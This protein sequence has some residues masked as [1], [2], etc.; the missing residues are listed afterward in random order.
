ME[1]ILG[2]D[3][4]WF[5]KPWYFEFHDPDLKIEKVEQGKK[6][7]EIT[8]SNPGGMP[9]P[10][11]LKIEFEDGS[12]KEMHKSAYVWKDNPEQ[13]VFNLDIKQSIKKITLGNKDLVDI[14]PEDN[15][16]EANK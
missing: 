15:K 9:V 14:S 2:E 11:H 1:D 13:V 3:L 6:Q 10:V 5:W 8:I 12:T 7:A 4:S 16:W